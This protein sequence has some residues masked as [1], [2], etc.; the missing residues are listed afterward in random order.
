[1]KVALIQMNAGPDKE[2]NLRKAFFFI[3]KAIENKAQF[4]LLPEVFNY[5]G[6]R[7]RDLILQAAEP[8]KGESAKPFLDLAKQNQIYLLLGSIIEKAVRAKRVYNTS[9]LINPRGEIESLYRKIHLFE[10]QF[11]KNFLDESKI[12]LPGEKLGLGRVFNF[13]LGM[14][15]CY[16]LRFPEFFRRYARQGAEL[17]SVPSVFTETTGRAHW[18]ILVR[19][20]AIEGLCYCLAPNQV[21]KDLKGIK[22]YGHSLV[23][24]PWGEI[25]AQGSGNEEEIVYAALE[26]KEIE[27]RRKILPGVL[28]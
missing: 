13:C 24:G 9:V 7:S 26:K 25:L 27:K 6:G 20:R 8:V 3:E 17:L 12:F 18:E 23:V 16:D 21:G 10:A 4:I 14:A 1:M 15:V 11:K 19:A 5:R 2:K 22:A 28:P